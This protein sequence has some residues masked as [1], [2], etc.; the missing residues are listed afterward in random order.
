MPKYSMEKIIEGTLSFLPIRERLIAS[1][2][3]KDTIEKYIREMATLV[4]LSAVNKFGTF[5]EYTLLKLYDGLDVVSH[6]KTPIYD[7]VS[8]NRVVFVSNHQSH[9]DYLLLNYVLFK[10]FN[11]CALI[12]GGLNL[13]IFPIGT[14]F[15][16]TGCFF[17]RRSFWNNELYR[18]TLEGYIYYLLKD[19][20]GPIEFFFEGGRSR[21][22]KL[23]PPKFG[24]FNLLTAANETINDGVDLIFIPVAIVHEIVPE[25]KSLTKELSG[26]KKEKESFTQLLKLYQVMQKKLGTVHIRFGEPL[27]LDPQISDLRARVQSLGFATHRGIGKEMVLTPSSVLALTLLD[28]PTTALSW[29]EITQKAK[30]IIKYCMDF[31]VPLSPSLN[32]SWQQTLTRSLELFIREGH[33]IQIKKDKFNKSY[34]SVPEF[35]RVE[36][37]YFKN[38]ILHH[39]LVPFFINSSLLQ[40]YKGKINDVKELKKYLPQLRSQL[41]FEFYLPTI[42]ELLTEGMK[43]ISTAIN[44]EVKDLEQCFSISPQEYNLLSH[45]IGH[46]MGSFR[47]IYEA[48]YLCATT[49]KS[50]EL[51]QFSLQEFLKYSQ[52]MFEMEKGHGRI[53]KHS[54]SYTVPLMKS[55]LA[56]F[57]H[58]GIIKDAGMSQ[59]KIVDQ[60][61][62]S[63]LIPQLIG[64]LNDIILYDIQDYAIIR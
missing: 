2:K 38:S 10:H 3:D 31:G 47:F 53:I 27:R 61:Q 37:F 34:Y 52:E 54:E 44:R 4:D 16:K 36:V 11:V 45:R 28:G 1:P 15:R 24:L 17:I 19:R 57:T 9:S 25:Q 48:Q 42:K 39:F 14:L 8:Q 20:V 6:T 35:A 7:L 18:I 13:N 26:G 49:L 5:L 32:D 30:S 62:V 58:I 63:S 23:M 29:D 46:I 41:K 56:Y 40:I 33:I 12:A 59:Y 50:L 51:P 60:E 43:I 21:S 55:N 22:G 64:I